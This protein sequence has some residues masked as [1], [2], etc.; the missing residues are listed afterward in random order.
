MEFNQSQLEHKIRT[1]LE[2]VELSGVVPKMKSVF[3]CSAA[4]CDQ[5][6]S[7]QILESCLQRCQ[8]PM[9]Q[10]QANMQAEVERFQ[11]RLTRCLET[12]SDKVHDHPKDLQEKALQTCGIA[13]FNEVDSK[14]PMLKSRL[15]EILSQQDKTK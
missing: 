5:G 4:C 15:L 6:S 14:V 13:C 7:G 11:G 2:E 1:S 9:Q 3:M 10:A 8:Q 12:C